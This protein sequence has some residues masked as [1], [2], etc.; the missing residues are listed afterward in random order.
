MKVREV[1]TGNVF[2]MREDETVANAAS[3]MRELDV[4]VIPVT[5]GSRICG[6]ITD[7]DITVRGVAG[8]KDPRQTRISEIMTQDICWKSEEATLEQATE[9]LEENK[10]RR[11]LVKDEAD[12]LVGIISL[13]DLAVKGSSDLSEEALEK[14]SQPARPRRA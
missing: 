14:I 13:G 10:I 12:Q 9:E 4:G 7:R 2:V 6:L 3:K 1:M 8:G 5:D 11:L